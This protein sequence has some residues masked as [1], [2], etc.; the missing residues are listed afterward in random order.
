MPRGEARSVPDP[1]G[2]QYDEMLRQEPLK[3][4]IKETAAGDQH[5]FAGRPYSVATDP[6][7]RFLP[8]GCAR[9]PPKHWC[10]SFPHHVTRVAYSWGRGS[11]SR[12]SAAYLFRLITRT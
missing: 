7:F 1:D 5:V 8:A 12:P 9:C 2:E 3:R 10:R 6:N 11:R 4:A